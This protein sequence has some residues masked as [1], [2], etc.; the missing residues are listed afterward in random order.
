MVEI[1]E[2]HPDG[3]EE[4]LFSFMD[5]NSTAP[6]PAPKKSHPFM[7]SGK[8]PLLEYKHRLHPFG[9]IIVNEDHLLPSIILVSPKEQTALMRCNAGC[10]PQRP[11]DTGRPSRRCRVRKDAPSV[12]TE[13]RQRDAHAIEGLVDTMDEWDLQSPSKRTKLA[14]HEVQRPQRTKRKAIDVDL[15]ESDFQSLLIECTTKIPRR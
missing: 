1:V 15:V 5:F 3:T 14:S 7:W 2:L 13:R 9:R 10:L 4:M 11:P 8:Q 12:H 6:A